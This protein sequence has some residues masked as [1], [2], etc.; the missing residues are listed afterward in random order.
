MIVKKVRQANDALFHDKVGFRI[1]FQDSVHAILTV[2]EEA[3]S[4][5]ETSH[6]RHDVSYVFGS[7]S[8][9]GAFIGPRR[10][11]DAIFSPV[12]TYS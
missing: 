8:S 6:V 4:V 12:C 11:R 5:E 3:R 10:G 2:V 1:L 9:A 7:R